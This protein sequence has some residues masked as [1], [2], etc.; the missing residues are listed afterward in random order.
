MQAQYIQEYNERKRKDNYSNRLFYVVGSDIDGI[1]PILYVLFDQQN[2]KRKRADRS[3]PYT[4]S[5]DYAN[6]INTNK[7]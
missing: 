5:V 2:A 3:V 6:K 7:P 1:S 4:R